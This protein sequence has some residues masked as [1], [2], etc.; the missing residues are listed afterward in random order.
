MRLQPIEAPRSLLTR[1][2]FWMSKR[3][4]GKVLMPL[5]VI[6]ARN[7]GLMWASYQI[8]KTMKGR[9]SLD[10]GLTTLIKVHLSM[11][12]GCAFCKDIALAQAV[13]KRLGMEKFGDLERFRES[14]AFTDREK[15]ALAFVEEA[16]SK[17][18]TDSTFSDLRRHFNE[19]EIVEITWVQAAESYYNAMSIPLGIESDGLESLAENRGT[20]E[21]H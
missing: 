9:L 14:A 20:D 8:E 7:P 5:K 16:N 21:N 6:Y 18:V 19:T 3:Q 11:L 10:A 13:Q 15:A 2:A 4:F 12:N 1:I 17:K